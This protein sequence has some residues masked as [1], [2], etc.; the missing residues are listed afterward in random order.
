MATGLKE[1]ADRERKAVNV[2]DH[3]EGWS[4]MSLTDLLTPGGMAMYRSAQ[5][6]LPHAFH[7]VCIEATMLL[8]FHVLHLCWRKKGGRRI[9][10]ELI[11]V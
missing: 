11:G 9:A 3:Y 1:E 5:C 2:E 7:R 6:V 8:E 4:V 10:F